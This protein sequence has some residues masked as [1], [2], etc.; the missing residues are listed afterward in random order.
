M[1][2]PLADEMVAK[3]G[4]TTADLSADYSAD[5]KAFARAGHS[6]VLM[7]YEM[8]QLSDLQTV[9]NLVLSSVG[10]LVLW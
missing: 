4:N 6:A 7:V 2:F 5:R 3:K 9:A 1:E 10:D 8:A